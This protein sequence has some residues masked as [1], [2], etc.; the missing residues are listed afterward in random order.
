MLKKLETELKI[1]GF[2]EQTIKAYSYY[3]KM[4]LDF[5]YKEKSKNRKNNDEVK[6]EDIDV[7]NRLIENVNEETDYW[8]GMYKWES[9][10]ALDQYKKSFVLIVTN[11]RA[12]NDI[13]VY[14]EFEKYHLNKYVKKSKIKII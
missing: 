4:F 5:L 6:V 10:E 12:I 7:Q 2:S 9:K 14:D 1:R 8:Q 13:V 3:N 11:K